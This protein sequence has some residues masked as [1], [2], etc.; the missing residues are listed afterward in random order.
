[1]VLLL[2]E[3]MLVISYSLAI[4]NVHSLVFPSF[5][6]FSNATNIT[7]TLFHEIPEMHAAREHRYVTYS[8]GLVN[9][10]DHY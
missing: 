1:M 9:L 7:M 5:E 6:R 3:Y 8:K 2:L 4:T 10:N